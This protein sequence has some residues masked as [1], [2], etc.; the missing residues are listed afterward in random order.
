MSAGE[1]EEGTFRDAQP[2]FARDPARILVAVLAGWLVAMV[3][4]F[5][6]AQMGSRWLHAEDPEIID[7]D[8][9]LLSGRRGSLLFCRARLMNGA[10]PE[11]AARVIRENMADL[12]GAQLPMAISWRQRGNILQPAP[13]IRWCYGWWRQF[14]PR[15]RR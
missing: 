8:V 15:R 10:D 4:H 13:V 6:D 12:W 9:D 2:A 11:R 3:E 14:V 7:V 1:G 5:A